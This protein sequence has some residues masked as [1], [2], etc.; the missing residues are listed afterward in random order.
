MRRIKIPMPLI[1]DRRKVREDVESDRKHVV[2]AA[3][4]RIMKSRKIFAHQ[5][6][7]VEV[8]KQ[9][10]M[11]KADIRQIKKEIEGLIEREFI[12]RDETNNAILKYMA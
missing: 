10:S 5:E 4:V 1:E 3:I 9:I 7:V 2:Q 8:A 11:F 6:L 12:E